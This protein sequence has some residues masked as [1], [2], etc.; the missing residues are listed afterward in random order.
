MQTLIECT[1]C[2]NQVEAWEDETKPLCDFCSHAQ[3]C[4]PPKKIRFF[5]AWFTGEGRAEC[6][7]CNFVSALFECGC[8][9]QHDCKRWQ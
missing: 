1:E 9:L 4:K 2:T 7:K 5:S 8:D 6:T 3:E